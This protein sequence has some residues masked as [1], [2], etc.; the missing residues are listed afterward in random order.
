MGELAEILRSNLRELAQAEAREI[1]EIDAALKA[2]RAVDK[3]LGSENKNPKKNSLKASE[4]LKAL[5]QVQEVK[6]ILSSGDFMSQNKEVLISLCRK[7]KLSRY[8]KL[9]KSRLASLLEE[10]G[11]KPPLPKPA[12]K[13]T[14]KELANLVE[15]IEKLVG[16]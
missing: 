3:T 6:A 13:R 5:N 2:S 8:S 14:K 4:D 1:R 15:K 16:L 10:N 12:A 9:N 7:N 11:V